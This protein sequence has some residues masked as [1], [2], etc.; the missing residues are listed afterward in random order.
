[1]AAIIAAKSSFRSRSFSTALPITLAPHSSSHGPK[2]PRGP[3]ACREFNTSCFPH[4]CLHDAGNYLHGNASFI[5]EPNSSAVRRS[6]VAGFARMYF[7]RI[8]TNSSLRI[9]SLTQNGKSSE[10]SGERDKEI[11]NETPSSS[12]TTYERQTSSRR[13]SLLLKSL[14]GLSTTEHSWRKAFPDLDTC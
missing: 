14:T 3:P 8:R 6:A 1:M 9:C 5:A 10:W 11:S 13:S 7:R 12:P 4:C 2:Q